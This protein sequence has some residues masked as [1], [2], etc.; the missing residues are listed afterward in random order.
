MGFMPKL[1]GGGTAWIPNAWDTGTVGKGTTAN[2]PASLTTA[3]VGT[4]YL[5]TTLDVDGKLV[6]WNGTAWVDATGAVV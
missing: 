6:I 3:D 4:Q 1:N 5:D 2:R